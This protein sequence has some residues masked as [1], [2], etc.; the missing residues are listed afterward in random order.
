MSK[1]SNTALRCGLSGALAGLATGLFGG[2]GGMV[3]VP[4]LLSF[5]GLEEKRAF[6][7][8]VAII[9]PLCLTAALV[10]GRWN[11]LPLRAA[12]PYLIGGLLGG[13]LGGLWFRRVSPV[14]LR[15]SLALLLLYGGVRCLFF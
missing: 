12:L 3:L 15:K 7:A 1:R 8:S 10:Y 11:A 13:A 14:F 9:C 5:C 4:L 6:A 2:G